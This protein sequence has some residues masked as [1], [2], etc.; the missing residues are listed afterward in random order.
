MTDMNKN[1]MEELQEENL[2]EVAGGMYHTTTQSYANYFDAQFKFEEGQSVQKVL[3]KGLISGHVY[4]CTMTIVARKIDRDPDHPDQWCAWYLV[5]CADPNKA[6]L[7]GHWYTEGN[8]EGGYTSIT[9][10]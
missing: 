9:R 10:F 1:N 3:D 8:F 4:T 7:A 5:D 2:D 6:Y